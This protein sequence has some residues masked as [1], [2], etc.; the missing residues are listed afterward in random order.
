MSEFESAT[1][2]L[3]RRNQ[4]RELS[5]EKRQNRFSNEEVKTDIWIAYNRLLENWD[6]VLA[7]LYYNLLGKQVREM[8]KTMA[9]NPVSS[10]GIISILN[11]QITRSTTVDW[12]E[13]VI[14]YYE[15]MALD[16]AYLQIELLLPDELKENYVFSQTEQDQIL[17]ARRRLPRQTILQDGFH[18]RRKRGQAIPLNRQRYN[19]QSKAFIETR[20]NNLLPDMSTTMKNNLNRA[21]RKSIDEANSFGLTGQAFDDYVANGISKSLGKKNLGR[22]MN[23]ARTEGT[24][25]SNFGLQ[26]SAKQTGLQ[27]E[28]EWITRRDGLV[29]D[30]HLAMDGV[31]APQ[32]GDFNVYGYTMNFPGDSSGGAPAGLVCNCRCSMISHEVRI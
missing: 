14:P 9:I 3:E 11:S 32:N 25:I 17:S 15:S 27:L 31:R 6:F 19:R 30:A 5:W 2:L 28:K 26:E 13:E 18:P 23:I 24:A 7:K 8:S 4:L 12:K 22:A 10:S 21:L 16:F 20:L 29:R 1:E